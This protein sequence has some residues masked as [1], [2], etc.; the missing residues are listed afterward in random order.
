METKHTDT[1]IIGAGVSGLGCAHVLHNAD[2]DFLV[3]GKELGGRIHAESAGSDVPFGTAYI[4][5]DYFHMREFTDRTSSGKQSA[6][7]YFFFD[8]KDYI[9]ALNV[10]N[11]PLLPAFFRFKKILKKFRQHIIDYRAAMPEMSLKEYFEKDEF[12]KWTWET[13][14]SDFV[15]EN[16]FEKLDKFMIDPLVSTTTYAHTDEINVAYYLGMALPIVVPTWGSNFVNTV[17]KMT[18]GIEDRVLVGEVTAVIKKDD[19]FVVTTSLG[20]IRA[21]NIVFAAPYKAIGH[22]YPGIPKPHRQEDI[23]VMQV[24]GTRKPPF[25][26]KPV[27]F[28]PARQHKGIY[29]LFETKEG[30]DLVYSKKE[31]PDL[32]QYYTDYTIVKDVYWDPVMNVPGH[33]LIDNKIEDHVYLAGDYNISGLEDA[34]VSGISVAHRMLR[35]TKN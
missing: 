26:N 3:I 30:V 5:E 2:Q 1:L 12:L 7:R 27:V 8:G 22:L 13:K 17:E 16:G 34:Y 14:A 9:T 35:E 23:H 21:K 6:S 18:A 33:E 4:C 10:K 24:E 31:N 15:K 25:D 11:L 19:A 32:S 28:L 29:T 20:E